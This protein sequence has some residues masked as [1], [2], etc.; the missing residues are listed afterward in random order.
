MENQNL[1]FNVSDTYEMIQK[2]SGSDEAKRIL[3]EFGSQTPSHEFIPHVVINGVSL[4][5]YWLLIGAVK[6]LLTYYGHWSTNTDSTAP[7][8]RILK[9]SS[10]RVNS[11]RETK[12]ELN[13]SLLYGASPSYLALL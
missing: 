6:Q 8:G 4:K 12:N 3:M 13:L 5:Q 11:R 2:L 10:L 1:A 7:S 9:E